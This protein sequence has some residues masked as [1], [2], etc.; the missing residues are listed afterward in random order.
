MKT[1]YISFIIFFAT[2]SASFS[3]DINL[4]LIHYLKLK[5]ALVA[6][7]FEEAKQFIL[8]MD[9]ALQLNQER[10]IANDKQ[11]FYIQK[12]KELASYIQQMSKANDIET[13]R[14]AFAPLSLTL[15]EVLSSLKLHKKPLYL[16]YCPMALN[17]TG[18]YWLSEAKE[19]LNPYFGK[20]ML[21][22]GSVETKF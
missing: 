7:Q 20:I 5:D 21:H 15:Y 2:L 10:I 9:T 3:Q 8:K 13:L 4:S 16:Q 14:T 19:I 11:A 6:G 1:L 18:A 12:K 17:D 22:C